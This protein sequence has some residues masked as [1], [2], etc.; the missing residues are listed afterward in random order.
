M[1]SKDSKHLLPRTDSKR[2]K[3]RLD[4]GE[5]H[6]EFIDA[7]EYWEFFVDKGAMLN[8]AM[9]VGLAPKNRAYRRAQGR[10]ESYFADREMK[11]VEYLTRH[12]SS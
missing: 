3:Q 7:M 12:A 1:N 4:A 9:W 6:P 11:Y 5:L 10:H 8:F 2:T